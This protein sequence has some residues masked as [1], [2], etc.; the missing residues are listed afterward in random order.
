MAEPHHHAKTEHA[1]GK[2][3][4]DKAAAKAQQATVEDCDESAEEPAVSTRETILG[5]AGGEH[6]VEDGR[7]PRRAVQ[8]S[9]PHLKCLNFE[10][11]FATRSALDS[12]VDHM[13]TD[14]DAACSQAG[15]DQ[16]TLGAYILAAHSINQHPKLT[17]QHCGET[18]QTQQKL[19]EHIATAHIEGTNNKATQ[20]LQTT[21]HQQEKEQ[22]LSADEDAQ[23]LY[24]MRLADENW[25]LEASMRTSQAEQAARKALP[26]AVDKLALRIEELFE[27]TKRSHDE[28][29]RLVAE[30]VRHQKEMQAAHDQRQQEAMQ[31]EMDALNV[32]EAL[33]AARKKGLQAKMSKS[34]FE[35]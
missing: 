9:E 1:S 33:I 26:A 7:G 21:K 22:A 18:C 16:T 15:G 12:H 31:H 8:N 34:R 29:A 11:T 28:L 25:A 17:C 13:G 10:V 20:I 4:I 14:S 23:Y 6:D 24:Q 35:T 32:Q 30:S 3:A 27:G 5:E 19:D 2:Q